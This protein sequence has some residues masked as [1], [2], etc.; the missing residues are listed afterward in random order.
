MRTI[1][2]KVQVID[3]ALAILEELARKGAPMALSELSATLKLPKTTVLRLLS[4]LQR[5]RFIDKDARSGDYR[6][7]LKLVELGASASAQLDLIDRAL[8]LMNRLMSAT[9]ESVLLSVLD[10]TESVAVEKVESERTVRVPL[11]AGGRAPTHCTASGKALIAYLPESEFD[12]RFGAARLHAFTRNTI[13]KLG[14]LKAELRRVRQMGYAVDRE[15]TEEGLKCIA[16]PV[17]D[18]GGSTV[19]SIGILGPAFRIPDRR[20]ASLAAE[21]VQAAE[22]LSK[23]L[24]FQAPSSQPLKSVAGNK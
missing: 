14:D 3:R 16:A 24:G 4:V 11:R 10:G 22:D 8:P 2:Y 13:V 7:G 21:V 1:P 12:A 19:A 23:E 5:H 18:I 20:L 15:E 17:M 9:N 6:L